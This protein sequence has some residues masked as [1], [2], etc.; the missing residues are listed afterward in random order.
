MVCSLAAS[1]AAYRPTSTK[2]DSI[3]INP[4]D[5]VVL[6]KHCKGVRSLNDI[7]L[8]DAT[9]LNEYIFI[10]MPS[11]S[12]TRVLETRTFNKSE[13]HNC[14]SLELIEI[15]HCPKV[16]QI[17]LYLPQLEIDEEGKPSPSNP[18]EEI[19]VDSKE[20]WKSMEW[21]HPIFDVKNVLRPLVKIWNDRIRNKVSV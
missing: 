14:D 4:G 2:F 17:P 20:W 5:T 18:L 9:D 16:K 10:Q 11:A 3:E 8:R 12:N 13:C 6:P 21:D 7:G 15:E 1:Y 19:R